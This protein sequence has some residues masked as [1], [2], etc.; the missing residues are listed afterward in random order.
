MSTSAISLNP[1]GWLRSPK[2]DLMLILGVA[3]LAIATGAAALLQPEWFV[4]LLVL[5]LWL[6]GY[7]HVIATFTRLSFDMESFRQNKFLVLGLPWI[8]L[9]ATITLAYLTDA[10]ALA[11][12]Y[13]YWQWFHY[14]RQSY[15]L[16][17]YYSRRASQSST[18]E[19]R[20]STWALYLL[21]LWGILHRSHQAQD[22]FLGLEIKYLPTPE[23]VVQ[24][25][26]VLAVLFLVGWTWFQS[27]AWRA[28]TLSLGRSL[29]MLSHFAVFFVG[30]IVIDDITYGWLVINVWHN[31][32]YLLIV[33]MYNANRFRDGIDLKHR[34]LSTL[35]QTH[36]AN[37]IRYILV[38]FVLSTTVYL[39]ILLF[40]QLQNFAAIPLAT[41]IVYQT[42]NFHHYIADGLIWTKRRRKVKLMSEPA[43]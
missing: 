23:F 42:I 27:K 2:F 13:L 35:S 9:G 1:H 43:G 10:W 29:Y 40:L 5:D 12:A 33:W 34:L 24:G 26:G 15:G 39:I 36:T 11:T 38:C 32:Q 4:V 20:I 16:M 6:L 22:K 3:F 18:V 25:V 37:I 31:A 28:E 41:I 14:T 7:P 17:R 30:Y 19:D 21:P 8:V